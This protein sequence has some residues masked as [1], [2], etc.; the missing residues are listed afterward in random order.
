[1]GL[2]MENKD[3]EMWCWSPEGFP[4]TLNGPFDTRDEALENA[5]EHCECYPLPSS[6][7]LGTVNWIHAGYYTYLDLDDLLD[8]MD[9]KTKDD[10]GGF[11]IARPEDEPFFDVKKTDRAQA[12]TELCELLN[13]WSKKWIVENGWTMEYVETIQIKGYMNEEKSF[14]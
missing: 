4:E 13:E 10:H 12:Q 8:S 5:R 1:M 2:K 9:E 14:E 3:G 11:Y 6:I 7:Q